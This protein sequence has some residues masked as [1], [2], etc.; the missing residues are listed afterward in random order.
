MGA[1]SEP[2]TVATP[3][4]VG[5]HWYTKSGVVA[6]L[7]AAMMAGTAV[8]FAT[9]V[10]APFFMPEL[11]IGRA[12]LGLLTATFY[13]VGAAASPTAGRW[14]DRVGGRRAVMTTFAL[15]SAAL[16]A[17]AVAPSYGLLVVAVGLGGA[18]AAVANPGTNRLVLSS[19]GERSRGAVVGLKQSGVQLGS[20]L[21]GAALPTV[22]HWLGW[23]AALLVTGA[24][25]AFGVAG[26]A[27][28]RRDRPRAVDGGRLRG[29]PPRNRTVAT[30]SLFSVLM[31]LGIAS[32]HTYLPVYAV[33]ALG[34]T[35]T[36][37]GFVAAVVG[38]LGIVSRVVWGFAADRIPHPIAVLPALAVGALV[39]VALIALA[40]RLG[41]WSLWAGAAVF[42]ATAMGW[43]GVAMLIA[44][45]AVPPAR[46]GWATGRVILAFYVGLVVSPIPFGV[47]AD[48]TG[49]YV[50]G[51]LGVA[52][53]FVAAAAISA[54]R[55]RRAPQPGGGA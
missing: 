31:G 21:A 9:P 16:A 23:R 18:A 34:E 15:A 49:S 1:L 12:E 22:A 6:A 29:A 36:V 13:L 39:G 8:Q 41:S 46:A 51:W 14:A 24:G 10:L 40:P 27:L 11:G 37:A 48:R 50:V 32:V 45:T 47:V 26:A 4:P 3:A 42:G 54:S 28:L 30:L 38:A 20:L 44:M 5:R 53:A 33:D 35:P 7:V 2:E 55:G 17:M 43:N 25:L 19:F 52:T